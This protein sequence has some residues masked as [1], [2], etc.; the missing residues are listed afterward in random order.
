MWERRHNEDLTFIERLFILFES[1]PLF[2]AKKER[3]GDIPSTRR[4]SDQQLHPT[5]WERSWFHLT[6]KKGHN[7]DLTF[8]ERLFILLERSPLFYAK[9]K[10]RE[11]FDLHVP[12]H[13]KKGHNGDLT[14]LVVYTAQKFPAFLAKKK[15]REIFD[16]HV[17]KAISNCIRRCGK[18]VWFHLTEKKGHNEDLTFIERLFILLESSPLFLEKIKG[19]DIP[20]K[21][22]IERS[23]IASDDV[24]RSSIFSTQKRNNKMGISPSLNGF[25]CFESS[26]PFSRKKI[27]DG[28]V[29]EEWMRSEI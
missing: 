8:I 24:E 27:D 25:R 10:G 6:E 18:G 26:P 19:G 29:R 9:N 22:K 12:S 21:K 3:E 28:D 1:S 7:G 23:A 20:S 17:N 16:L 11:I 4:K 5:M 14:F 13:G 15:G 2:L